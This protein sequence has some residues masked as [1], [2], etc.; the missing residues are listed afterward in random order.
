[1]AIVKYISSEGDISKFIT[2]VA[3]RGNVLVNSFVEGINVLVNSFQNCFY[4]IQCCL[5]FT[6]HNFI[7]RSFKQLHQCTIA[8]VT[9]QV[10][11]MIINKLWFR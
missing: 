3:E 5:H 2:S 4:V 1:M 11:V 7:G 6:V 9:V 8:S 10:H